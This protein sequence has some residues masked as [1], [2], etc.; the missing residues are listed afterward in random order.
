MKFDSG[1]GL[2]EIGK[3]SP[4]DHTLDCI[5]FINL[6]NSTDS[7]LFAYMNDHHRSLLL[8]DLVTSHLIRNNWILP[9]DEES[10]TSGNLYMIGRSDFPELSVWKSWYIMFWAMS[11]DRSRIHGDALQCFQ[12][13]VD[14]NGAVRVSRQYKPRPCNLST[15][16]PEQQHPTTYHR[17]PRTLWKENQGPCSEPR[18]HT[19]KTRSPST[20]PRQGAY[21]SNGWK[22]CTSA[23]TWSPGCAVCSNR[24]PAE[25]RA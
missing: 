21:S 15:L 2:H 16:R 22:R 5:I 6:L 17:V 9:V 11:L 19:R 12:S 24:P 7:F 1:Q 10:N 23:M 3:H 20:G 14:F 25:T 8:S 18:V 4:R 13:I